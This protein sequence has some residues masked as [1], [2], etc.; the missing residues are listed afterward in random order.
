MIL[1]EHVARVGEE[2]CVRISVENTKGNR[3]LARTSRR[4]ENGSQDAAW[5]SKR[6]E[7]THCTHALSLDLYTWQ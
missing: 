7:A 5:G 3:P 1:A 6:C 4:W 2:K